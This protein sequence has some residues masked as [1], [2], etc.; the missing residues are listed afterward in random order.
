M[1]IVYIPDP[2]VIKK[3]EKK[4]G[5]NFTEDEKVERDTH[6][7]IFFPNNEGNWVEVVKVLFPYDVLTNCEV[8]SEYDWLKPNG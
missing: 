4:L 8:P 5:R 7:D 6:F 2:L 1:S 3:L